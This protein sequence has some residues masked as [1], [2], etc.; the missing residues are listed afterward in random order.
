MT[1]DVAV[2]PLHPYHSLPT[3]T[4][5]VAGW[6]VVDRREPLTWLQNQ[7]ARYTYKPGYQMFIDT[8]GELSY[9]EAM[10][11]GDMVFRVSFDAPDSRDPS[12]TIPL[13]F[14]CVFHSAMF[15]SRDENE[16]ASWLQRTLD[17]MERHESQEWLRRDGV[18]YDDPHKVT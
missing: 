7:L 16:F 15:D 2:D 1:D 13:V 9:A 12:R 5:E 3:G 6:L 14:S 11:G 10:L 4:I 17:R 18:I 8:T